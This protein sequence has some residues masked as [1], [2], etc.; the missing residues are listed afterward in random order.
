[1]QNEIT[2]ASFYERVKNCEIEKSSGTAC[3]VAVANGDRAITGWR[4]R[5]FDNAIVRLIWSVIKL[6][7][8]VEANT[9]NSEINLA[10][11]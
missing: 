10:S 1:M 5:H 2:G 4:G 8:H 6:R 11:I 7:R 3:D 9:A